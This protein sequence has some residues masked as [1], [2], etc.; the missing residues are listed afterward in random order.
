MEPCCKH[1]ERDDR[2]N[3]CPCYKPTP[4][5]LWAVKL[6]LHRTRTWLSF[7]QS[8]HGLDQ[9][10]VLVR[11]HPGRFAFFFFIASRSLPLLAMSYFYLSFC[12]F[13]ALFQIAFL[14]WK[15]HKFP[16]SKCQVLLPFWMSLLCAGQTRAESNFP[17]YRV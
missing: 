16:A 5:P 14:T 8:H 7:A 1:V 12:V 11:L 2:R 6:F 4:I 17:G 3:A 13:F 9:L 10:S 15:F